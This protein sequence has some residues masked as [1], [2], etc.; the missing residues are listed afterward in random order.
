MPSSSRSFQ[1]TKELPSS[2]SI[3]SILFGE[4]ALTVRAPLREQP[5]S[6]TTKVTTRIVPSPKSISSVLFGNEALDVGGLSRQASQAHLGAWA[7]PLKFSDT[8]NGSAG[9]QVPME[10]LAS[11]GFSKHPVSEDW[12]A[13]AAN[14]SISRKQRARIS[15]SQAA[16]LEDSSSPSSAVGDDLH[17]IS[18]EY[19]WAA[20]MRS[21]C[22]LHRVT[23]PPTWKTALQWYAFRHLFF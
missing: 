22:N 20:K 14:P 8:F 3:S 9:K 12:P 4:D 17:A 2:P 6:S 19:P 7:S 13:L 1:Q 15:S 16:N 23:T 5:P 18:S 21:K 11:S 10:T